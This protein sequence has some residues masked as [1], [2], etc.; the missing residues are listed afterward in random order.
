MADSSSMNPNLIGAPKSGKGGLG[1]RP[2][3]PP[4]LTKAEAD[5]VDEKRQKGVPDSQIAVMLGCSLI[6]IQR[7]W[8]EPK[9]PE[10]A[11]AVVK[12]HNGRRVITKEERRAL[13]AAAR[14]VS[15]WRP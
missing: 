3:P 11:G 8:T 14:N 13:D 15:V 6:R 5:F 7:R 1:D 4:Y 12:P 10:Q 9:E 2:R